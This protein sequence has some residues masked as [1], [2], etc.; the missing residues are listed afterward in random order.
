M[1]E[2]TIKTTTV[3][4]AGPPNAGKGTWLSLLKVREGKKIRIVSV[5]ALLRE[6]IAA[7]TENGMK[8]Q[9]FM[10]EGKLCPDELI[11]DMILDVLNKAEGTVVLDGYPRTKVQADAMLAAG[12]IPVFAVEVKRPDE[13]LIE[14][15]ADRIICS[16]C[17][18]S[19]TV[20]DPFK[21]PQVAGVC[22][23]CGGELKRRPDDDPVK[24][25]GRLDDYR[26]KT[27]PIFQVMEDA[28]IPVYYINREESNAKKRF[29][30]L[31]A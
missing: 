4:V 29:F 19:Y 16:K 30:E 15:A 2:K 9:A 1:Q 22:D 25:K 27:F 5:S 24:V 26:E 8:A 11:N 13:V 17:S 23:L 7:G 28:G 20:V 31:F 14:R 10:N 18:E 12:I 21:Q 6:E 3:V